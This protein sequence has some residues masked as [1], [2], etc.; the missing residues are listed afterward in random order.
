[1]SQ[2]ARYTEEETKRLVAAA[3]QFTTSNGTVDWKGLF[4]VHTFPGREPGNLRVKYKSLQKKRQRSQGISANGTPKALRVSGPKFSS[5]G[6]FARFAAEAK[7]RVLSEHPDADAVQRKLIIR[8]MWEALD[9]K[10]RKSYSKI[11]PS[12]SASMSAKKQRERRKEMEFYT[13]A[14]KTPVLPQNRVKRLM[15]TAFKGNSTKEAVAVTA[16]ATEMFIMWLAN[17]S[18]K[19]SRGKLSVQ[20]LIKA[21]KTREESRFLRATL[22]NEYRPTGM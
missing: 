4:K 19:I 5:A 14:L 6:G 17:K 20:D 8:K 22:F 12:P 16:K 18:S 3:E 2:P 1:M 7:S 9:D 11:S 13:E 10:Q 15:R 21:S